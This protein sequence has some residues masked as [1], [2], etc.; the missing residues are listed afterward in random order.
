M[1]NGKP[2]RKGV[3]SVA[4]DP[5]LLEGGHTIREISR[6]LEPQFSGTFTKEAIANNARSRVFV[7]QKKGYT[8]EKT[9][10]KRV[11]LVAP[12]VVPTTTTPEP[13]AV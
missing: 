8:L 12:V 10:D 11:R 3:L 6:L 13:T 2:G 1:A 5:L 9:D 7:Y 4:I